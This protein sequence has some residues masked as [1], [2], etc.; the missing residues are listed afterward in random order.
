LCQA[1]K[2]SSSVKIGV[3]NREEKEEQHEQSDQPPLAEAS[4]AFISSFIIHPSA[5][6]HGGQRLAPA[7]G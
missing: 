2:P 5:F 7:I 3:N 6:Q 4:F 1:P